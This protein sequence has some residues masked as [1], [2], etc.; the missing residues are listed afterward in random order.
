MGFEVGFVDQVDAVLVAQFVP[1]FLVRVVRGADGVDVVAL[2]E[3][4]VIDHV[5]LGDGAAAFGVELVAVGA[6]EHDAL[7]VDGQ[8][9]V[10]DAEAA[11]TDLLGRAFD[12]VARLVDDVDVK[13]VQR[14]AFGAPRGD[15]LQR[16]A[17]DR[18]LRLRVARRL[19]H[20]VAVGVLQGRADR[21]RVG[22]VEHGQR[23]IEGGGA[24]LGIPIGFDLRV[25]D[26][27]MRAGGEFDGAEQ[28][29]QTPEVLILKPGGAGV[30]VAGDGHDV[31]P[32]VQQ[33]GDVE[34]IGREAVLAIADERAVDP[35]VDRRGHAVEHDR[36]RSAGL[37]GVCHGGG[38][39]ELPAVERDVIVLRD[40]RFQRVL[41]AVPRIL[42]VHVLVVHQ[43]GRLQVAR[44]LDTLERGV[45]E[46]LGRRGFLFEVDVGGLNDLD[47]PL[48]VKALL[49]IGP[50]SALGVAGVPLVAGMGRSPVHLEHRRVGQPS[51]RCAIDMCDVCHALLLSVI[52]SL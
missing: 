14:R 21:G 20:R 4:H 9:A 36:H 44:N 11:E 28:A 10:L 34:L 51:L 31:L 16:P 48:A 12:D 50:L 37:L 24:G 1:A 38:D 17:G 3:D 45:V 6:L 25:L 42:D 26:V 46:R 39:G 18:G 7:A 33:F 52:T 27:H 29:V 47:P 8:D 49:E 5:L 19:P 2:A 41:V 22:R 15:A 13:L 32:V 40:V 23:G 43:T 35:H 30:F